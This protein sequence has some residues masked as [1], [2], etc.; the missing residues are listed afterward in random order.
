MVGSGL[1]DNFALGGEDEEREWFWATRLFSRVEKEAAKLLEDAMSKPYKKPLLSVPISSCGEM[2]ISNAPILKLSVDH[3]S[4]I[5]G[6]LELLD[7]CSAR[8]SSR[9]LHFFLS[10]YLFRSIRFA[11]HQECLDLI[12]TVSKNSVLCSNI[13]SLHFDN[14]TFRKHGEIVSLDIHEFCR[15]QLRSTFE[16]TTRSGFQYNSNTVERNVA[17]KH[18]QQLVA[19]H[20]SIC[21]DLELHLSRTFNLLPKVSTVIL[22][23]TF[24]IDSTPFHDKYKNAYRLNSVSRKWIRKDQMLALFGAISASKAQILKIKSEGYW[25]S[26]KYS[27]LNNCDF[28]DDDHIVGSIKYCIPDFETAVYAKEM[29]PIMLA[30]NFQLNLDEL[31]LTQAIFNNLTHL[32]LQLFS[33][34][35]M[36]TFDSDSL[37]TLSTKCWADLPKALQSLTHVTNLALDFNV[38]RRVDQQCLEYF[39]HDDLIE[40]FSHPPIT[41]PKLQTLSLSQFR[42]SG[43]TVKSFL[44]RHTSIRDLK[45]KYVID[46][47]DLERCW[48]DPYNPLDLPSLPWMEALE[49]MRSYRLRR[50]HL[51]GIEG[52]CVG[53]HRYG[54]ENE[55]RTLASIHDYVLHGYG[56]NPLLQIRS[57]TRLDG[58]SPD[59]DEELW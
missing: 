25:T 55:S 32:E 4:I 23:N 27:R 40:L 24:K 38:R 30:D 48:D 44:E 1:I 6:Y 35:D 45:L 17:V 46:L 12:D 7:I 34:E 50:V 53:Y 57:R 31:A 56:H 15:V 10:P 2:A 51:K 52:F 42:S 29:Q 58:S 49:V 41:F 28:G 37:D 14:T 47:E 20:K 22:S 36:G 11:P 9:E 13:R 39:A 43:T 33:S 3:F 26:R 18:Y 8:L 19:D 59:W 54:V 21:E 5:S 16:I